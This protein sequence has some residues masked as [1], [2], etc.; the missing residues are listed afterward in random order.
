MPRVVDGEVEMGPF[1]SPYAYEWF[2][3]G[4]ASA[5]MGRHD[6]AAIAFEN[7]T[8]APADDELLLTR[9]AEEYELSGASRR[10]D[11]TLAIARR[12]HPRSPRVALTQGRLAQHRGA[13]DEALASYAHAAELAP[14]WDEPVL[15]TAQALQATRQTE[16][17]V[18]VLFDYVAT[19]DGG[20][21]ERARSMLL[22][23][24]ERTGDAET[25]LQVSSLK[26]TVGNATGARAAAE[27]ALR[28]GQ[29]RLAARLLAK[30]M[31]SPT[32]VTLW[33]RA[34]LASGDRE[35]VAELLEGP[36]GAQLAGLVERI[37]L[38]LRLG[39]DE[40]AL[41]LLDE[42]ER[43][44][45]IDYVKG[46]ALSAGGDYV[47]AASVLA[48]VPLGV[49]RFEEARLAFA[50]CSAALGRPG[51]AAEALSQAPHGSLALRKA[52]AEIYVK[53]GVPK[54]GLR[55]LD[56]KRDR[57]RAA[58]AL[59]FERAGRFEEAAAYY[60]AA[61]TDS[62]DDPGIRARASAE[63]LASRGNVRA[64]IA[65]LER[66]AETAP[67]DLYSRVRLVELLVADY[68]SEAAEKRGRP[69]LELID[70][71]ILRSHLV[72][73]LVGAVVPA[74]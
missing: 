28:T 9:L 56:P 24:L 45:T 44:P 19:D 3:E 14:R 27:L 26:S 17:A 63:Q 30:T 52:L 73:I 25:L 22:G 13:N 33:L 23:L 35:K 15:A 16:R 69:T 29:P 46:R 39:K 71:P 74:R 54:N 38:L 55:L 10:A 5:S 62:S 32:D 36:E 67:D 6:E 53:Q 42:T 59:L 49:A 43:S 72:D 47:G 1:V 66:L 64:A 20:R 70:E 60:A 68:Q 31:N 7:A 2:I 48:E 12:S 58:L 40:S 21:S 34:A 8:A 65:V 18:A 4:E 51:A 57:E 11:R 50:D 37:D 61:K 41:A